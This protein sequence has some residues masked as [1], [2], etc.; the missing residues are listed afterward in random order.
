MSC[1]QIFFSHIYHPSSS[2]P[3]DILI[4]FCMMMLPNSVSAAVG[5]RPVCVKVING[6]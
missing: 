4:L 2:F 3:A 1:S 6:N 5:F